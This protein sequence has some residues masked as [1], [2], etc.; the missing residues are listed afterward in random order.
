MSTYVLHHV[1]KSFSIAGKQRVDAIKDISVSFPDRGLIFITGKSGAG[2]STLLNLLGFFLTPD[3]GTLTFEGRDVSTLAPK[4]IREFRRQRIAFCFQNDNLDPDLSV[5]ENILLAKAAPLRQARDPIIDLLAS[6]GLTGFEKRKAYELSGGEQQRVAIARALWKGADILLADEP[7]GALDSGSAAIVFQHLKNVSRDHLVLVVSHDEEAARKYGDRCLTLKDGRIVSDQE[8][9]PPVPLPKDKDTSLESIRLS[10]RVVLKMGLVP[11]KRKPFQGIFPAL[12]IACSVVMAC[13]S[14]GLGI[15]STPKTLAGNILDSKARS[16]VLAQV[17]KK[18]EGSL[19]DY[20]SSAEDQSF[21][22]EA[23][24]RPSVP[25][26]STWF[27]YTS[28]MGAFCERNPKSKELSAVEAMVQ[29]CPTYG[30]E[31][32]TQNLVNLGISLAAGRLPEN[33]NEI[34][35]PLCQYEIYQKDGYVYHDSSSV[36]DVLLE[37]SAIASPESFLAAGPLFSLP[38]IGVNPKIVGLVDTG[39][40]ASSYA[41]SLANSSGF[42]ET[43]AKQSYINEL[44]HSL[45]RAIF[46]SSDLI[47]VFK[48]SLSQFDTRETSGENSAVKVGGSTYFIGHIKKETEGGYVIPFKKDGNG[49]VLPLGAAGKATG[50]NLFSGPFYDWS[51]IVFPNLPNLDNIPALATLPGSQLFSGVNNHQTSVLSLSACTSYVKQYGLPSGS[52][53]ALLQ[54]K[55]N[56]VYS[57]LYQQGIIKKEI[58]FSDASN[59]GLLASYYAYDLASSGDRIGEATVASDYVPRPV[60]GSDGG[61]TIT[62]NYLKALFSKTSVYPDVGVALHLVYENQE[63]TMQGVFAGVTL[64]S[65]DD[66]DIA[67]GDAFFEESR[68]F[69]PSGRYLGGYGAAMP[70]RSHLEALTK[71]YCECGVGESAKLIVC[72]A[73]S[74]YDTLTLT[75]S[76]FS[77]LLFIIA[78]GL[79]VFAVLLV[80]LFAA[81]SLRGKSKKAG[82]L[83]GLGAPLPLLYL[84]LAEEAFLVCLVGFIFGLIASGIVIPSFNL[85]F[86][87]STGILISLLGFPIGPSLLFLVALCLSLAAFLFI[88]VSKLIKESPSTLM[89]RD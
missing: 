77:H 85:A 64:D 54:A 34:A 9:V 89:K 30:V 53:L 7:T 69:Y 14:L 78:I 72:S 40:L 76:S 6:L 18:S 36:G 25:L 70:D 2:K 55:A 57:Y 37:P 83:C 22:N 24:G 52:N 67:V 3:R 28:T 82:L 27:L 26:Y 87:K 43:A 32:T 15:G 50:D 17:D 20:G 63:K 46:L 58:D 13:F 38:K 47:T 1:S 74:C 41:N 51:A 45:H 35:L 56:E 11:L 81:I 5:F 79:A 49:I 48:D 68:N 66:F 65:I 80:V 73:L 21:A 8:K 62:L 44:G 60:F 71:S 12:L 61:M 19:G 33:V 31:A 16:L 42:F 88:P 39:F 10:R 84:Y 4:Q 59:A 29:D 75:F 86:T 23:F